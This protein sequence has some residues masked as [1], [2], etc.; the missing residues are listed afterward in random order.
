MNTL[1]KFVIF[2]LTMVI[3]F[4][5]AMIIVFCKYQ[6]IPDSLVPYFF[7]V[8]GGEILSCAL[9]KIFKLKENQPKE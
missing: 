5:I 2:S 1:T 9:L 4:T 7:A 6:A 3:A 8:F